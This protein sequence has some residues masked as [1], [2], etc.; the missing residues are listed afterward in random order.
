MDEP[1]KETGEKIDLGILEAKGREYFKKD[2][3]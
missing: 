2:Q 3:E 1:A